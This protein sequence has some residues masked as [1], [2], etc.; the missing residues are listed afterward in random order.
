MIL[1]V[2]HVSKFPSSYK[3]SF[4]VSEQAILQN[5]MKNHDIQSVPPALAAKARKAFRNM[6]ISDRMA[7]PAHNWDVHTRSLR[8]LPSDLR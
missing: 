8:G 2:S 4:T 6:D 5:A 7:L 1:E 3:S